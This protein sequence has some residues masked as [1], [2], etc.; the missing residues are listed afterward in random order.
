M[1]RLVAKAA[2]V[3]R[4]ER[5]C[6]LRW[7]SHITLLEPPFPLR[8]DEISQPRIIPDD[9]MTKIVRL[10]RSRLCKALERIPTH[11]ET[12]IRPLSLQNVFMADDRTSWL[13]KPLSTS[14]IRGHGIGM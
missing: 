5:Y 6:H 11:T 10:I 9:V 14:R 13:D 7:R 8:W 12:R 2:R 3:K 1:G 4:M